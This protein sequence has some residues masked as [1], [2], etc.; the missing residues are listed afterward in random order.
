MGAV[1]VPKPLRGMFILFKSAS[2]ILLSTIVVELTE[3]ADNVGAVAVPVKAPAK[4]IVPEIEPVASGV[5]LVV[6]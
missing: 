1:A 3:F 2:A 4:I 5:V 6:I